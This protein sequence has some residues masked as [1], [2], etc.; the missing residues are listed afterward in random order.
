MHE[1]NTEFSDPVVINTSPAQT[2]TQVVLEHSDN[3][4]RTTTITR[5]HSEQS[6]NTSNNGTEIMVLEGEC[7]VHRQQ[8]SSG[9]YLRCSPGIT[10]ST[11]TSCALFIKAHQFL[12]GDEG[13]RTIDTN[14]EHHWLPGPVEGI[15]ICPLH[16][17]D[18]ESIMLLRWDSAC[19]FKPKLD[20]Q[21]EELL[22]ISGLLQNRDQ[23][24]KPYSWI[25]NPVEDWRSWHGSTGTLVYY[26]SGH[27]PKQA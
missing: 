25:R 19:E 1:L 27:F 4:L 23:L 3:P 5:L 11:K 21:G 9:D 13:N 16:V 26:K 10:L 8:Y 20:P 7:S 14:A 2:D 17:F 15:S 12:S 18:S 6:F 24:F 22:V